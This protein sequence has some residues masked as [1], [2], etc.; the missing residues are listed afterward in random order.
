MK[1]PD[2]DVHAHIGCWRLEFDLSDPSKQNGGPKV[3]ELML[4]RRVFEGGRFNLQTA[5]FPGDPGRIP[6]LP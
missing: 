3:N 2:G 6:L 5:A 4:V 1:I